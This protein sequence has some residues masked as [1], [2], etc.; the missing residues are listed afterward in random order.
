MRGRVRRRAVLV[1]L[2]PLFGLAYAAHAADPKP[3]SP[4]SEFLEYLGSSDDIDAE[5]QRDLAKTD[6]AARQEAKPAPNRGS[7]ET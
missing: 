3:V 1:G 2:G 5:L 7:G 4:D 6:E